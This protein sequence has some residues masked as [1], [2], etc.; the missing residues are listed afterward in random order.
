MQAHCIV[1]A[2]ALWLFLWVTYVVAEDQ[3][4]FDRWVRFDVPFVQ[5]ALVTG[6][7]TNPKVR[8]HLQ[9]KVLK[10]A[11]GKYFVFGL[12]RDAGDRLDLQLITP[13]GKTI[14]KTVAVKP[15]TYKIQRINGIAKK[16]MSPD[17]AQLKR[18]RAEAL[19]VRKA[20]SKEILKPYFLE[21]FKWPIVGT[22]TGVYGSQRIF[23]GEP[24]RPHFGVD[25]AAPKGT[26]VR[27]PTSGIVT[28][29][30]H[31]MF[32]SG[33]TVILDHGFGVSSTFLHM[34]KI[35]VHE[36]DHLSQG[37]EIGQVGSTGRSTGAH[38]DWRI[39]W[40]QE[41]LDPAMVA[42]PMPEKLFY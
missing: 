4:D 2:I 40:L 35:S 12:G 7:V 10:L 23:N 15:R 20:R 32:Y 14:K 28:L 19:Q 27:A 31:D 17:A 37:D 39:N 36:G 30:H 13:Q 34:Y 24:R 6:T 29:V 26:V 18:I 8:L 11:K 42:G 38:L 3:H 21:K 9:E 5:G 1:N 25:I 33:G 41:R 16:F 22:I